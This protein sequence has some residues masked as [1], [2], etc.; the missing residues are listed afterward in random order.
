MRWFA[1]ACVLV[2]TMATLHHV[3]AASPLAARATLALGFVLIAAW[4]GGQLAARWHLPR[5]TGYLFIGLCVGPAWLSLVRADELAALQF[6]A[7]AGISLFALLAGSELAHVARAP[8]RLGL[9]RVAAAAIGLPFAAV[10]LV[11]LSVSPWFPLT[12]HETFGNAVGVALILGALAAVASPVMSVVTLEGDRSPGPFARALIGVAAVQDV[13]LL[14]LVSFILLIARPLA[15]PGA[16]NLAAALGSLLRW[17]GSLGAGA[18]LGLLLAQSRV[19]ERATEKKEGD[20][21]V[22]PLVL[23]IGCLVP[24]LGRALDIEPLLVALAA[25]CAAQYRGVDVGVT[26]GNVLRWD[27]TGGDEPIAAVCFGIAGAGLQFEALG[28]LWPWVVLLVALRA[29]ALRHGIRWVGER[30]GVTPALAREGWLGLISQSGSA[31][32]LGALVRRAFPALGVSLEALILA[33]IAIH[34]VAGPV[35]FRRALA[36][37]TAHKEEADGEG[38]DARGGIGVPGSGM[39]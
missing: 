21:G 8:E 27:R 15:A 34:E 22:T 28:D 31:L 14:L 4:L 32:G 12:T 39:R 5:V 36:R 13:A 23:A 9:A 16:L 17:G 10:S 35:C 11:M 37:V 26:V 2:L 33:T 29:T 1:S 18:V 38:A 19:L 30:A 24:L 25:G 6:F 3:T 20:F 7:D